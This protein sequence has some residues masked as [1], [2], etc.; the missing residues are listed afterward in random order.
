MRLAASFGLLLGVLHGWSVLDLRASQ[1]AAPF[2]GL[3]E[4]A[5]LQDS[6]RSY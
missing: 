4:A 1:A 6:G 2:A 3:S 5:P